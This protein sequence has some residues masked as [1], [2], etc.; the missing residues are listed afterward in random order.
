MVLG[1]KLQLTSQV[2]LRVPEPFLRSIAELAREE[3][4]VGGKTNRHL[5]AE[6]RP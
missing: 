6:R 3:K 1:N 2:E 4:P 5:T